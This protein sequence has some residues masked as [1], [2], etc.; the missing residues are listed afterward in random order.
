MAAAASFAVEYG[1]TQYHRSEDMA[2]DSVAAVQQAAPWPAVGSHT[3]GKPTAK[4]RIAG[5]SHSTSQKDPGTTF[6]A[7][8]PRIC[9]SDEETGRGP[10]C[11]EFLSNTEQSGSPFGDSTP[12]AP[13]ERTPTPPEGGTG[14]SAAR[15]RAGA[16]RGIRGHRHQEPGTRPQ[17]A[18]ESRQ[19]P[20]PHPEAGGRVGGPEG[21]GAA[22]DGGQV[23]PGAILG[24][25]D[26]PDPRR[27]RERGGRAAQP[28]PAEGDE[29]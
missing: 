16:N 25:Q 14:P 26:G 21:A 9:R 10:G 1:P 2:P 5:P 27:E 20:Q 13:R 4:E 18:K 28:V 3:P 11:G 23:R 12:G 8:P 24:G 29:D 7:P 6:P 19:E 15:L 17:P 22:G